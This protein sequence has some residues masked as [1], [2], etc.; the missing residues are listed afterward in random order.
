MG[1]RERFITAGV[2]IPLALWFVVY[3]AR[4][5]L[6][7]VLGLQAICIQELS[8]LLRRTRCELALLLYG[9]VMR[10]LCV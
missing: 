10:V 3:D 9:V 2:A 5:C 6:A 7:L 8:E 4:S 1:V